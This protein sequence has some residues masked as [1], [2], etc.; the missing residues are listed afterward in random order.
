MPVTLPDFSDLHILVIG[1]VMVDRY[2]FGSVKRISPEAPVPVLDMQHVENRL[3]GAANVAMNLIAL[4]AKV[5]LIT[6]AGADT[7]GDELEGM[8]ANQG[9]LNL[10][11]VRDPNRKTTLKTRV[12]AGN[13][14]LLR[15]DDEDKDDVNPNFEQALMKTIGHTLVSDN[16]HGVI[17]QDYNKGLLTP[18]IITSTIQK[19]RENHIPTFVDPKE[20]NFFAYKN[21]TIFKPNKK[22]VQSAFSDFTN[23]FTHIAT[24]IQERLHNEVTV[25]TLGSG[26][27]FVQNGGLSATY[28]TQNR[29][30]ADVCGAG[31]SV[32]SMLALCYIKGM[33]TATMMQLANMA[34][35]QVCEMPGVTVV[36]R[37]KLEK[38]L[39]N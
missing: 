30:I 18:L 16:I 6:I 15:M 19:C 34:G 21:C 22:E 11:M 20:K 12:M 5:T 27:I 28:P 8:I 10:K 2:I 33:D 17:L 36:S 38:E 25:I 1:D 23:D 7:T 4:G 32:I 29:V 31:D 24:G 3:G 13:Q 37:E 35:G 9:L 26:G 39:G 14:Q